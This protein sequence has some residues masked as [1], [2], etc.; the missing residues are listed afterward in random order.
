MSQ[1]RYYRKHPR[2]HTKTK[3]EDEEKELNLSALAAVG[4]LAF[5]FANGMF[6]GYLCKRSMC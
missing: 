6:L 1:T 3:T 4:I 2:S 5:T